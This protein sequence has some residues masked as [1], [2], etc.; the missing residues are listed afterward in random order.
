MIFSRLATRRT[1][2]KRHGIA[3]VEAPPRALPENKSGTLPT[4]P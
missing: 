4:M 3:V 1:I 2:T